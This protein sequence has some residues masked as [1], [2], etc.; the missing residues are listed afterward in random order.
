MKGAYWSDPRN[1]YEA[2]IEELDLSEET[3]KN[4]HRL[5]VTTI[6][7]C[8]DFFARVPDTT[9]P[10]D[11]LFLEAMFDVVLPLLEQQ[12]YWP[13]DKSEKK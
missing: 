13:R 1:L 3:I 2:M 5:G 6:G 7:D 10:H 9:P 12:G 8:I 4:V 11:M